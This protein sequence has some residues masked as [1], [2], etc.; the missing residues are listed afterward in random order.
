MVKS[1]IYK[2][3]RTRGLVRLVLGRCG[4]WI[5]AGIVIVSIPGTLFIFILYVY[6]ELSPKFMIS[7][8]INLGD[9]DYAKC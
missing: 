2:M 3:L 7:L 4:P 6:V 1:R 9:F 5:P 8:A